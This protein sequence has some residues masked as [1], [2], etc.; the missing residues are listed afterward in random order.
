MFDTRKIDSFF[1]G[2]KNLFDEKEKSFI[3]RRTRVVR[4]FKL[5]LPCLTAMLFAI[6]VALFDFS[7]SS[8]TGLVVD[9]EERIYF[10]KFRIKNTVFE[11]TEKDNQISII[12]A[13]TV[14]ETIAGSKIYNLTNPDAQ[15]INDET[16]ITLISKNGSYNQNTRILELSED[17]VANYNK[18]MTVKT[19]KVSYNFHTMEGYGNNK[20]VGT[21]NKG[22]F[23]AN[24]FSFNKKQNT[25]T[26]INDVLLSS[27]DIEVTTPK[28]ATLYA[29]DNK[30]IAEDAVVKKGKEKLKGDLLTVF[31][32]DT[33]N[34]E[35]EKA[36]SNGNP[37]VYS[38][39]E[40]AYADEVQYLPSSSIINL[41]GNVKIVKGNSI[42]TANKAVYNQTKEEFYL[43]DNVKI[44]QQGTT[45]SADKGV[46]FVKKNVAELEKN[47]VINK[48][49]NMVKGDK[50]ISDFNTS[51]S[52][53]IAKNGGRISGK[54]IESKLDKKE[55]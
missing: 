51:K 13:D 6:G 4:F 20:I 11:I 34:F 2:E 12:K 5:F 19:A 36:F 14:E 49:G 40:R 44:Q 41:N 18:E 55:D 31:F 1:S 33:K 16:I 32:K 7:N 52:R 50:A 10:E 17:V 43:Y 42:A 24:R 26:L 39:G 27:N 22:N 35:I 25:I 21:G 37:E 29:N 46:Y 28:K 8:D 48:D 47:V 53:L 45:A 54:L 9:S 30:F 15:S 38:N 3:S 23:S